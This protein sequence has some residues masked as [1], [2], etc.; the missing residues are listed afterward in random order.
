MKLLFML[1]EYIIYRWLAYSAYEV[2]SPFVFRFITDVLHDKR[3]F[4]AFEEIESL[5]NYL[6]QDHSVILAEDLGAG[7]H[8]MQSTG[9]KI[10]DIART[11]L[12]SQRFGQ[13]LFRMVNYYQPLHILELGTSLGISTLYMAK[14]DGRAS[15]VTLEGSASIAAMA[16]KNFQKTKTGNI[17]V[18]TGEFSTT[19]PLACAQ[20]KQ[21]DL[22][23][24]DGNHR[25]QPTLQYFHECLLHAADHTIMV[26]DDIHWSSEMKGAWKEIIAHPSVTLSI[27]LFFKGIIFFRKDFKAKQHFILKY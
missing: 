1:R 11:N 12:V 21:L 22:V 15:V 18:I 27:D 2:H 19:L 10:S 16:E 23:F 26:F 4:D 25:K 5:R 17:S 7:S 8:T 9:R 20:L 24:I 13:L 14:A 6:L 3:F